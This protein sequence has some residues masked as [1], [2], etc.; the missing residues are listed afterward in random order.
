MP[1]DMYLQTCILANKQMSGTIDKLRM[2]IFEL[3]KNDRW[4][5]VEKELPRQDPSFPWATIDVMVLNDGEIIAPASLML[6]DTHFYKKGEWVN[7]GGILTNVTHW[8]QLP[9]LPEAEDK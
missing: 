9:E 2:K 1:D 8:R 7:S 5:P 6:Q 3:E 4:F